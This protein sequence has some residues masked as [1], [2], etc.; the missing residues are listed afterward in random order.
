MWRVLLHTLAPG[1]LQPPLGARVVV[2]VVLPHRCTNV[3]L[4]APVGLPVLLLTGRP[5]ITTP[6][7]FLKI[8]MPRRPLSTYKLRVQSSLQFLVLVPGT[9][10]RE[11]CTLQA[12][13][14][15]AGAA[16]DSFRMVGGAP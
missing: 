3:Q 2:A 6:R 7:F 4:V 16:G 9:H 15:L 1:G 10:P 5:R 13:Q 8:A 12:A 11:L 14:G